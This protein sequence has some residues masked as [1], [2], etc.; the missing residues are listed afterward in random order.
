MGGLVLLVA[1]IAG[2]VGI[3]RLRAGEGSGLL[4]G[5][6]VLA[7]VLLAADVVAVWAMSAK[8]D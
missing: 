7:L 3:Y 5:T 2:G 4:R 8:P 1:L 6:L